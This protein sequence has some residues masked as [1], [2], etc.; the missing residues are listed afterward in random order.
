MFFLGGASGEGVG[1]SSSR[2]DPSFSDSSADSDGMK[3]KSLF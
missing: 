3:K 1:T 2:N